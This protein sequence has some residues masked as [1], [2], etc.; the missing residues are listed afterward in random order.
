MFFE[1]ARVENCPADKGAANEVTGN[2]CLRSYHASSVDALKAM[3]VKIFHYDFIVPC[4][5]SCSRVGR[6]DEE[7]NPETK[8]NKNILF[9]EL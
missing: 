9:Q 5:T 1:L 7:F 3:R 4:P 2:T 8:D 6:G